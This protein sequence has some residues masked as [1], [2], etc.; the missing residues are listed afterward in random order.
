MNENI[1]FD[2]VK[3]SQAKKGLLYLLNNESK[4]A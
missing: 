2:K 4:M 1:N 3:R